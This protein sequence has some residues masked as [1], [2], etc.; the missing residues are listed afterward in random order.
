MVR[1]ETVEIEL[2]TLSALLRTVHY[3]VVN[4]LVPDD[5]TRVFG[6][7][8]ALI[9]ASEGIV[10]KLFDIL[11]LLVLCRM[12]YNPILALLTIARIV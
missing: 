5:V 6:D 9:P 8:G 11:I 3:V 1:I 12:H 2:T 7:N 10:R 4:C